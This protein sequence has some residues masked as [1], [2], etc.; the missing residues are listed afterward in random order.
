MKVNVK[1][2][3]NVAPNKNLTKK[4]VAIIVSLCVVIGSY[5]TIEN[6]AADTKNT[7]EVIRVKNGDGLE[8]QTLINENDIEKYD[9]IRAEYTDDMILA[10]DFD[11]VVGK[12]TQYHL[13]KNSVIYKD[14]L[15][16]EK[17]IMNEWLYQLAEDEEVVTLQY[18]YLKCGGDILM[19]GDRVR[20]RATFEVEDEES[21]QDDMYMNPNM[22]QYGRGNKT[23]RTEVIFDSIEVMDMLNSD[24]HSIYE[25]YKEVLRLDEKKREEVMK[26]EDFI[27]SILPKSLVLAGTREQINEYAKY[28]NL[29][30]GELLITIL[31]RESSNPIIDQLPTLQREVES[32]IDQKEK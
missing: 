8:M 19:P 10:D 27:K 15:T 25:V 18:N 32:W 31:S 12:Y 11:N 9:I 4:I 1:S 3:K 20:I 23:I 2:V 17:P 28:A 7:I 26:S 21:N 24:S 13:R 30:D 14:Q 16:E 5:I 29:S 22:I 6:A